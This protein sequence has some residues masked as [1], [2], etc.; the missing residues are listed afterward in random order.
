MVLV[1]TEKARILQF[2]FMIPTTTTKTKED[3]NQPYGKLSEEKI[4]AEQSVTCGSYL[5]TFV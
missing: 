5:N 3:L 2:Y 4:K 1:A